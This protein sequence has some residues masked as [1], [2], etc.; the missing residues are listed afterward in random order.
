MP[1]LIQLYWLPI[2]QHVNFILATL[3]YKILHTGQLCY[4]NELIDFYENL[5]QLR[6][7]SQGLLYCHRSGTVL[8]LRGLNIPQ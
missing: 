3:T 6:S 2:C 4:L 5:R 1:S 8:A 7:S